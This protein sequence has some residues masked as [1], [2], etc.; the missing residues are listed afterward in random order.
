MLSGDKFVT[1]MF[2]F[3][4]G[5][6]AYSTIKGFVGET[7]REPEPSLFLML[8]PPGCFERIT[9][10]WLCTSGGGGGPKIE[11]ELTESLK[12]SASGDLLVL[13]RRC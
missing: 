8:S 9:F 13:R 11:A 3:L 7:V 1:S 2:G 6:G 4:I 5:I 10:D 12:T